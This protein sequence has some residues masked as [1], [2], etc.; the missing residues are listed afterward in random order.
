MLKLALYHNRKPSYPSIRAEPIIVIVDDVWNHVWRYIS[1]FSKALQLR[2]HR[3]SKASHIVQQVRDHRLASA[4]NLTQ[5]SA[6]SPNSFIYIHPT[7]LQSATVS[8]E[9]SCL[10]P[11]CRLLLISRAPTP[12]EGY[13]R[14]MSVP[15][16]WPTNY[17]NINKAGI[18][19][20]L[21]WLIGSLAKQDTCTQHSPS[22]AVMLCLIVKY[23]RRRKYG[24]KSQYQMRRACRLLKTW[25]CFVFLAIIVRPLY[26]FFFFMP[27]LAV[28]SGEAWVWGWTAH[29]ADVSKFWG[30]STW[31]IHKKPEESLLLKS[32]MSLIS[33]ARSNVLQFFPIVGPKIMRTSL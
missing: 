15:S 12:I 11:L 21:C 32:C 29:A 33:A 3:Q 31:H 6:H 2:V 4:K 25:R 9:H 27:L 28:G 17:M 5:L 24:W 10:K 14:L 13:P 30:T 8:A 19:H 18:T 20:T 7:Y 23:S 26:G 22:S 16:S 1:R